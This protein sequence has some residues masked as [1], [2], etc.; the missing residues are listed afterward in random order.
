MT[1]LLERSFACSILWAPNITATAVVDS[2]GLWRPRGDRTRCDSN[3]HKTRIAPIALAAMAFDRRR[4][5]LPQPG[6]KLAGRKVVRTRHLRYRAIRT[7]RLRHDPKLRFP[8]PAPA[9]L[10]RRDH[11]YRRHRAMP[12]VTISTALA[13]PQRKNKAV[14]G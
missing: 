14:T 7:R 5:Q 10:N 11:L 13:R 8:A 12:I 2:R 6:E 1:S 3:R 4:Q 9:S